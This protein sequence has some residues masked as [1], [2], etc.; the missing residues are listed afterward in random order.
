[1]K[2][3]PRRDSGEKLRE[4]SRRSVRARGRRGRGAGGAGSAELAKA[5]SPP[6]R[7]RWPPGSW[8]DG[9]GAAAHLLLINSLCG[10]RAQ[11]LCAI[12]AP[13]EFI[14]P[15]PP[16]TVGAPRALATASSSLIFEPQLCSP[17][18]VQRRGDPNLPILLAARM[19]GGGGNGGGGSAD[20][21]LA[22]VLSGR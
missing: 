5:A 3:R 9:S 7:A 13:V 12:G 1:M 10:A 15:L 22:P 21:G 4:D 18:T 19:R 16:R 14:S 2:R 20:P 8:T 17:T 11:L 6:A